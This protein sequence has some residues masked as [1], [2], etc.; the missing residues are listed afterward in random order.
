M[1]NVIDLFAKFS[2]VEVVSADRISETDKLFCEKNQAAYRTLVNLG[3]RAALPVFAVRY[4]D[5]FSW[6]RVTPL[7]DKAKEILKKQTTLTEQQFVKMLFY[8]RFFGGTAAFGADHLI[9]NHI[10]PASE[11]PRRNNKEFVV[12]S[13]K[14]LIFSSIVFS[15]SDPDLLR[16]SYQTTRRSS[17]RFYIT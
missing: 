12:A 1:D 8:L 15:P 16:S 3:N 9:S 11:L 5:D 4:A 6:W 10:P 2:A 14:S 17:I 13:K 7:N